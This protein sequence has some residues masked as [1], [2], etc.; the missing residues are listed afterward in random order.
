MCITTGVVSQQIRHLEEQMG[1][2]L[3]SRQ[4]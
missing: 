1:S 3:F 2:K 4:G